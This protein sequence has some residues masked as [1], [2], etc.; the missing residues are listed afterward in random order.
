M[1]IPVDINYTLENGLKTIT[2]DTLN[3]IAPEAAA[4]NIDG[5]DLDMIWIMTKKPIKVTS[6]TSDD[7]D[8]IEVDPS[9][10]LDEDEQDTWTE[11][12]ESELAEWIAEEWD[13]IAVGTGDQKVVILCGSWDDEY[14]RFWDASKKVWNHYNF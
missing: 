3:H 1:T 14:G 10:G 11:T 5:E 2:L 8:L 6:K 13:Q 12:K 9:W 4:S 7:D